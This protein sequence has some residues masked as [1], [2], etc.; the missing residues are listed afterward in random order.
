MIPRVDG[1]RLDDIVDFLNFVI[2]PVVFMV[3]SGHLS[4]SA[5]AV[6]PILA[7]AYG[8]SQHDSKTEDHFFLGWPSYWNVVALYLWLLDL[9]PG[10]GT[11]WVVGFSIAIFVRK[12]QELVV[13]LFARVPVRIG[14]PGRDP[15]APVGVHR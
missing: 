6:A 2:V 14:W 13:H 12:D 9:T 7:S 8:F 4:S 5:W 11:L 15:E 3:A 10:A 1:R